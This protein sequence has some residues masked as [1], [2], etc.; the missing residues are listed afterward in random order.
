LVKTSEGKPVPRPDKAALMRSVNEGIA[1]FATD[2]EPG[3]PGVPDR[4]SFVCECGGREC[5]VWVE[6]EL[7][8]YAAIRARAGAVLAESHVLERDEAAQSLTA[9]ATAV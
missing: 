6:L 1:F 4:W 5:N 9:G 2:L 8:A 3:E 7:Q